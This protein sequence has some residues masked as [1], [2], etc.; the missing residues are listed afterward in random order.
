MLLIV[1]TAAGQENNS[2]QVERAGAGYRY[3]EG[4]VWSPDGSLYFTDA[5]RNRIHKL[6]P[7]KGIEV[8]REDSQGATGLA[9]DDRGRLIVCES[10]ARR[11]T[12][13]DAAGKVAV[14]AER[15]EGKRLNSPNDVA[16]RKDGNIYFT[17]PA[18]GKAQDARELPFHAVF[19]LTPRGELYAIARSDKRPN[20]I[21]L[22]P[23]GRVLYVTWADERVI[24]AYDL[25]R[26]GAASN[27][28]ILVSG[29]DAVPGGL[30]TDDKG[31]LYVA[32]GGVRVYNAEGKPQFAV[33]MSEMPSNVAF[34]DGDLQGLY[35]TA[36]T[37]VFRIRMNVKGSA[38]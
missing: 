20:G 1:A 14:L 30:K 33:D 13:I 37:T 21:A 10:A 12:R 15:F 36:R 23:G 22:A 3:A 29:L 25:D 16:V 8:F 34:G 5:P 6:T 2:L 17:D 31:N 18:F 35:V 4:P 28:R 38:Q 19:H 27:E 11:L 9:M 24:R 26:S 7:G 32:C